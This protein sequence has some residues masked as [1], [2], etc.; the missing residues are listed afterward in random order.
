MIISNDED[1]YWIAIKIKLVFHEKKLISRRDV[2][3]EFVYGPSSHYDI[4][5]KTENLINVDNVS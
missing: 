5:G 1:R 4:R 2:A 3:R